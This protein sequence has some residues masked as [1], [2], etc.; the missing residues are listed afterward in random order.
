MRAMPMKGMNRWKLILLG[1]A[2]AAA[3]AA[4]GMTVSADSGTPSGKAAAA[5]SEPVSEWTALIPVAYDAAG[6]TEGEKSIFQ[7][8][9]TDA[10]T[11]MPADSSGRVARMELGP[12]EKKDFGSI[13]YMR[14]GVYTYEVDRL[15]KPENAVK[16]DMSVYR[17]RVAALRDGRLETIIDREGDK[18][19]EIRYNDRFPSPAGKIVKT[20]D[21]NTMA[22]W[23]A[24]G[25]AAALLLMWIR[26]RERRFHGKHFAVLLAA[27]LASGM[28]VSPADAATGGLTVLYDEFGKL[29]ENYVSITALPLQSAEFSTD[30]S[31][32]H[33]YNGYVGNNQDEKRD[34]IAYYGTVHFGDSN[35]TEDKNASTEVNEI[36][37][38][39]ALRWSNK[40]LLSDNT[41]ADVK[42]TVSSW[43]FRLGKNLN[44]KIDS[45]TKVYV[46]ILQSSKPNSNATELC[47]AT[48]RTK[49]SVN[50]GTTDN[51]ISG[52]CILT[53]CK[54]KLEILQ[55]GTDTPIDTDKYPT[56]LFGFRDLDVQ[57][58]SIAAGKSAEVRYA[59]PYSEGVELL[60]G[61]R[62]PVV[63]APKSS[64]NPSMETLVKTEL[65]GENLRIR[66]DGKRIEEYNK[67]TGMVGDTG[68]YYSGF[69]APVTPKAW[70]FW[71]TGSVSSSGKMMGTQLGSQPTVA[72]EATAGEGGKI[73]KEGLKT[74]VI[75]SGTTYDYTPSDGYTVSELKVDGR[76]VEFDPK[77]GTYT[78]D[79]L[80]AKPIL[81]RSAK[82]GGETAEAKIYHIHVEFERQ[83]VFEVKKTGDREKVHLGDKIHYTVVAKQTAENASEG[84]FEFSD[85]M[86][87]GMLRMDP[88][89]L[90]TEGSASSEILEKSENGYRIRIHS[91]E[92]E[93]S[94]LTVTYDAAVRDDKYTRSAVT[95]T[96][97]G[98]TWSV[99][100]VGD[101]TIRK[102]VTGSLGD[103]SKRFEFTLRLA[104]LNPAET[105]EASGLKAVNKGT[106]A[107]SGF[108]PDDDGE[109][110]LLF[111]LKGGDKIS[112]P[113][114][115]AGAGYQIFEAKSDHTASYVQKGSGA[116]AE[117]VRAADRN[118]KSETV[119]S[120]EREKLDFK[121][122]NVVVT[123]TNNR[124][125]SPITGVSDDLRPLAVLT[126][127]IAV[128]AIFRILSYRKHRRRD[129][130]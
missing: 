5:D 33:K 108:R 70:S 18:V 96:A 39:I 50:D 97:G 66:G 37:G 51:S 54:V 109:A 12:G 89:T 61:F 68:T 3:V 9:S 85:D 116:Q 6:E 104:G 120:T 38:S 102:K 36:D 78:F 77:G 126:A 53:K 81:S 28:A 130:R 30:N 43:S 27:A 99:D 49:Y 86:A 76:D 58:S 71:W 127:V 42:I 106:A 64:D 98:S 32:I 112:I 34:F 4:S 65:S 17:V 82:T 110:E 100:P 80:Y 115:P 16:A 88:D 95:N 128:F 47:T 125:I 69:I 22:A 40:A 101:L 105:Y 56:A 103:L 90:K 10:D 15:G 119:L 29:P 63:L 11:P 46:P 84:D 13:T 60:G 59:G 35:R 94:S 129:T 83:P 52:A 26:R 1:A 55:H 91:K 21:R 92:K 23:A 67:A 14:P 117:F 41:R 118:E 123:F 111:T 72:V 93:Q 19:E 113:D 79:N 74:Y 124:E 62:S 73:E 20:G 7:L 107:D 25:I 57:D 114:L 122:G 48:P 75:N 121:D 44:K 87:G 2:M 45:S 8:K 31:K 24:A